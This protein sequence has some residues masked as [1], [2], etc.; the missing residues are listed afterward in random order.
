[1]IASEIAT[2]TEEEEIRRG[3]IYLSLIPEDYPGYAS[4]QMTLGNTWFYDLES[5][6]TAA[7]HYLK[8]RAFAPY[9]EEAEFQVKTCLIAKVREGTNWRFVARDQM[10]TLREQ[11]ADVATLSLQDCRSLSW[12]EITPFIPLPLPDEDAL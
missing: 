3:L 12:D 11:G 10:E 1:M 4:A 9:Q 8:A 6:V 2:A 7:S 5:P